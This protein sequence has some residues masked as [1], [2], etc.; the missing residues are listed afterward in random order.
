M[1]T[2]PH[3]GL[4]LSVPVHC[5]V[6]VQAWFQVP[7][8]PEFFMYTNPR[9][10][11]ANLT[12]SDKECAAATAADPSTC[13]G[14]INYYRAALHD[15]LSGSTM[16]PIGVRVPVLQ[17]WGKNDTALGVGLATT[18]P[19]ARWTPHPRSRVALLDASHWVLGEKPK[20]V[21]EA[22]LKFVNEE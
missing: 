16:K 22:I 1:L 7:L 10:W 14:M 17:L 18:L 13:R 21:N 9:S 2:V 12:S 20:E 3:C 5:R 19:R 6:S 8:L 15:T 4:S 11:A